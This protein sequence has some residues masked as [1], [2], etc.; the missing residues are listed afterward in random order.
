MLIAQAA[1]LIW[2]AVVIVLF[3]ALP[4][5]EAIAWAVIGGYL[6]LPSAERVFWDFP[7]IPTIDKIMIP[8][9][10][11]ILIASAYLRGVADGPPGQPLAIP[12]SAAPALQSHSILPGWLPK[13]RLVQLLLGMLFIGSIMTALSN[14]DTLVFGDTVL[15]SMS[16]YDAFSR[17][18]FLLVMLLPFL[19]GRKFL[20]DDRGHQV[21]LA[22]LA[23]AGAIYVL[24]A[25]YEVRMS[26]QLNRMVYG[27]FPHSWLQHIRGGGFRPLVFLDHGLLLGMYLA[28]AALASAVALRLNTGVRRAVFVALLVWLLLGLVAAKTLG[29]LII[30]VLF[31]PT[32]LLLGRRMQLLVAAM[33]AA[34]ILVYPVLRGG[35]LVPTDQVAQMAYDFDPDRGGSIGFRFENEDLLLER[36]N[37]RPAFGW[38]GYSRGR[39]FD[40]RGNDISIT[41]GTWIITIGQWGWVGYIAT[42]GL[43][44]LPMIAM[45]LRRRRYPVGLATSG[46]A[47]LVAANLIDL[48][49]N[50]SLSTVLWLSA[51]ALAGRLELAPERAAEADTAA[52]SPEPRATGL[53]PVPRG[54][55]GPDAALPASRYTRFAQIK[56]RES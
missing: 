42:F 44:T 52:V 4:A 3:R 12:A 31:L 9:L 16:L 22:I 48:I 27:F 35:G 38:G 56:R 49:P 41:D 1:L 11:A 36:A 15:R 25:L 43:L 37:Q 8:A 45:A 30:A 50:S 20:A 5:R 33:V 51:G 32:A 26:P 24:P 17:I 19:L 14:R 23:I 18:A 53:R 13:S 6:L 55:P 39:I 21:L 34:V 46:L 7:V 2:P 29:A 10:T 28:C 40:D 54:G 47:I